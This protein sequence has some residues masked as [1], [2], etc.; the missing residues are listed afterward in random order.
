MAYS[1]RMS[2]D[3]F[4]D[5]ISG[6]K[7]LNSVRATNASLAHENGFKGRTKTGK[8]LLVAVIDR[9]INTNLPHVRAL[10]PQGLIH[11]ALIIPT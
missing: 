8:R 5:H 2:S 10:Q 3:V 11:P 4:E 6:Q 7:A 1:N 9:E